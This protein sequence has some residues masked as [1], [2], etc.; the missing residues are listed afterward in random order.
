MIIYMNKNAI[1]QSVI[2]T[3]VTVLASLSWYFLKLSLLTQISSNKTIW[4]WLL[5]LIFFSLLIIALALGWLFIRSRLILFLNLSAIL[6]SFLL[7]F[8]FQNLYLYITL[9]ALLFLWTGSCQAINEKDLRVKLSVPKIIQRGLPQIMTAFALMVS[10]IFYNSPYAKFD[11]TDFIIPQPFFDVIYQPF[12]NFIENQSQNIPG[13]NKIGN[14][15]QQLNSKS[16]PE[17]FRPFVEALLK[18]QN[19]RE[20]PGSLNRQKIDEEIKASFYQLLNQQLNQLI[21]PYQSYFPIVAS[22]GF[23]FLLKAISVPLMWVI[24]LLVWLLFKIL[25]K[26]KAVKIGQRMVSQETIEL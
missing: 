15:S 17:Q 14:L 5:P 21:M 19:K 16:I 9:L 10:I 20:T 11:K 18:K 1:T 22:I 24:L 13:Q 6:F 4:I 3:L 2:L 25:V 7:V 23:F 12:K 8:G 26:S